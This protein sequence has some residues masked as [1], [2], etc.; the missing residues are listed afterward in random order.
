MRGRTYDT[1]AHKISPR[2][3]ITLAI[4]Q[5]R[6]LETSAIQETEGLVRRNVALQQCPTAS[7]MRWRNDVASILH[8]SFLD[9]VDAVCIGRAGH[10]LRQC[11]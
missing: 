6:Q 3:D 5:H 8:S 9:A 1:R 10:G 11:L 2:V 7:W 4:V